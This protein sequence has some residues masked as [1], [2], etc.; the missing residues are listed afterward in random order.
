MSYCT[1]ENN[2]CTACGHVT[3]NPS[4][5][6][7]CDA[8]PPVTEAVSIRPTQAPHQGGAG[9]ELKRLLRGPVKVLG[10]LGFNFSNCRCDER[11]LIMDIEGLGWCRSNLS[12]IVGWLG[13][14]A[15]KQNLPFSPKGARILVKQ[16]IRAA[17]KKQQIKGEQS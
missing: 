9:T 12:T 11:A 13:E 8:H 4:L 2:V 6:R 1:Y 5:V 3:K 10:W 17:A 15:R 16:A 14:S 7:N